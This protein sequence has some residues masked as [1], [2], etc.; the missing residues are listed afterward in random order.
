MAIR[1]GM[2]NKRKTAA[3]RYWINIGEYMAE[4]LT[5]EQAR[6][7][8]VQMLIDGGRPDMAEVMRKFQDIV[9]PLPRQSQKPPPENPPA[10]PKEQPD[11]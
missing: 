1:V 7:K 5:M 11:H 4:G 9:H 8:M 6:D 2:E 3:L 10:P